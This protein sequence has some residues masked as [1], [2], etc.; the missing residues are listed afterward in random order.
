MLSTKGSFSKD[1][2][3][4][5][6]RLVS[7]RFTNREGGRRVTPSLSLLIFGMRSDQRDRALG[8]QSL[9]PGTCMSLRS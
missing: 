9:L 6:L 4:F 5:S 2:M 8:V 3:I 7:I 1:F